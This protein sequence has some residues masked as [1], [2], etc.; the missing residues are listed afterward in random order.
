MIKKILDHSSNSITGAAIIISGTSLIN[1]FV[2]LARDRILAGNFGAGPITDAY[3]TAFKIPD[4]IYN[5]LV[6]GALTAGFIPV[7]TRLYYKNSNKEDAWNL[8]NNILNILAVALL[9]FAILGILFASPIAK[10]IAPGLDV[11]TQILAGK[12]IRIMFLSP[13]FLGIS[14]VFGGILQSLK[15][16]VLYSIA[17]IFYNLGIIFGILVLVPLFGI[18]FLAWGVVLG[19]FTHCLIQYIAA[20]NAGW[21]YK[22]IFKPKD[23]NTLLIGKLMIPRTLALAISNVNTIIITAI[24]SLLPAGA[25]ATYNYANNLQWVPIGIVGIPFAL[26]VFPT[27]SEKSAQKDF[28]GFSKNISSTARQILFLIIPLS[29]IFML[30][31]AQIVRVVLGSGEFDWNATIRA[32]D[33][34][35]FFSLGLFA[36]A[37]VPL[38]VR[39]FYALE[40]TK[41]PF[42]ISLFTETVNIILAFILFKP[43]GVA[44]LALAASVSTVL[45]LA[46]LITYLRKIVKRLNGMELLASFWKI[47]LSALLMALTIQILKYP[48]AKIFSLQYF[49]GVFA[50]GLIAGGAGLLVYSLVCFALKLPEFMALK[51]SLQKRYLK[52]QIIPAEAESDILN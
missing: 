30:L 19:A 1:K 5:L 45:N 2:G 42:L 29:V 13:L 26:A 4:L 10:L 35:A 36:Q 44:G 31:R 48:L 11:N 40:N 24:A 47:M 12:F 43:L 38:F 41:T 6:V 7:F 8:S 21:T 34:L 22:S 3:Y 51:D 49:G 28:L 16:F 27:L 17:P 50:Q 9:F 18:E 39:G 37:L 32:A 20:K 15:K 33:A 23:K 52:K 25:I 46:L 14:M